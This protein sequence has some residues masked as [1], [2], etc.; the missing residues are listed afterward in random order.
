MACEKGTTRIDW[1]FGHQGTDVT[2]ANRYKE[3]MLPLP[4][5][6]VGMVNNDGNIAEEDNITQCSDRIAE[7]KHLPPEQ[8]Q[9]A[10]M[11]GFLRQQANEAI[12]PTDYGLPDEVDPADGLPRI[13]GQLA[14]VPASNKDIMLWRPGR[15]EF[16]DRTTPTRV[17]VAME[18]DGALHRLQAIQTETV[19]NW[20]DLQS[21][22][23]LDP[24]AS[25]VALD[26]HHRL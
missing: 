25:L 3:S 22:L 1:R 15:P 17:L 12:D 11:N 24:C 2:Y 20:P 4:F 13:N 7:A 9:V 21:S 18:M 14:T 19:R 8:D 10:Q 23:P 6:G 26:L 5:Q 16:E